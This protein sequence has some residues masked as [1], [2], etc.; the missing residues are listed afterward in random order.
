MKATTAMAGISESTP[1]KKIPEIAHGGSQNQCCV[2]TGRLTRR[3]WT[4]GH[5]SPPWTTSAIMSESN[6]QPAVECNLQL[7]VQR[8][9]K[10]ADEIYAFDLVQPNGGNLP[11]FSPGSHVK[12]LV[13]NGML[14]QYS[15]CNDP[16]EPS[17]Y[18]LAVKRDSAGKGGSISL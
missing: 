3:N 13:P 11:P 17:H 15:I 7:K 12:V 6:I 9:E 10:I 1:R 14:R 16:A 2:R 4:A 18:L 5:G 8:T